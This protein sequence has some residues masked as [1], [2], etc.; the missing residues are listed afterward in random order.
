MSVE[1]A[2]MKKTNAAVE[3][4]LIGAP[5]WVTRSHERA[6]AIKN[7]MAVVRA[8]ARVAD[9][10]TASAAP[11]LA[12]HLESTVCELAALVDDVVDDAIGNDNRRESIALTQVD[13][14]ELFEVV[15]VRL[16]AHAEARGV[17]LQFDCASAVIQG[18]L[19]D[20]VEAVTNLIANALDAT[21]EGGVVTVVTRVMELGEHWWTVEDSGGGIPREVLASVITQRCSRRAG[22]TG[23]GL[24]IAAATIGRHGGVLEVQASPG[25]GT[26]MTAR[27]PAAWVP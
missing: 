2:M 15:A 24:A 25:T 10:Y 22:G 19:S 18:V 23:L 5:Q 8:L 16:S 13:V 1:V 12:R 14:P 20:L 7:R 17:H 9:R 3:Q 4:T 11:E 27:L 21:P 26:R 6:H